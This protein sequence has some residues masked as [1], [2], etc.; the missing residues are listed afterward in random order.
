[1]KPLTFARIP[2][3]AEAS[4]WCSKRGLVM[5]VVDASGH[6]GVAGHNAAYADVTFKALPPAEAAKSGSAYQAPTQI[7]ETRAR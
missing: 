5:I 3:V 7:I 1:M 4:A 2:L 6:D